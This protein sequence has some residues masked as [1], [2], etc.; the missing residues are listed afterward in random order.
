MIK[1]AIFD[2]D[3]TLVDSIEDIANAVNSVLHRRGLPVHGIAEYRLMV[4]DGARNLIRRALSPRQAGE[5]ELS[6]L[7]SEFETA[8]RPICL[9]RTRA[10]PGIK[11]LLAEL[12]SRSIGLCVLSNKPEAFTSLIVERLFPKIFAIVRGQGSN[13]PRKP[14]PSSALDCAR[15]LVVEPSQ[16]L[17]L[18]DSGVDIATGKAAGMR[19]LGAGWG[20]R[21]TEE[22]RTAGAE[23]VLGKPSELLAWLG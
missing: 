19:A 6:A 1:A 15:G 8:Y 5:S 22:L 2:L 13:F 7:L 12:A 17:F 10:Y 18:G 9:D 21:G 14:D 23:A 3:G 4:G 20:F 16:V 11:E